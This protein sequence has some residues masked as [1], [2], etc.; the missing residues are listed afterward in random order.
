MFALVDC[1][2]F[3]AS[4]EQVFEPKLRGLP[5]VVLSNNDGCI[6][7]RSAEAK[8]LGIPMGAPLFKVQPTIRHHGVI[9]RSS[10]YALYG[11][12]S[13]RVMSVLERFAPAIEIYSIDEAF[14]E[15]PNLPPDQRLCWAQQLRQTVRQWLGIPIA[16][17]IAPTKTLAKVANHFAK[18]MPDLEGVFDLSAES[19]TE[20]WLAQLPVAD[21]W[22]IGRRLGV[23]CQDH[24]IDTALRLRDTAKE[25]LRRKMGIVGVRLQQELRGMACLAL[26]EVP[27]PKKETCVSRS[28]GSPVTDLRD[29]QEAIALYALRAGEKLR[30]QRQVTRVLTVFIRSSPFREPFYGNAATVQLPVATQDSFV[31]VRE[32]RR[33]VESLYRPHYD[34]QKAGILLQALQPEQLVQQHLWVM[35]DSPERQRLMATMDR[36]NRRF[37]QDL[38]KI[39]TRGQAKIINSLIISCYHEHIVGLH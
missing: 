25:R 13:Q 8:A 39:E 34:Y 4:C 18:R 3:Y 9:V 37:G 1:N 6:V 30:R 27:E 32:A 17:G 16:I 33:L 22:G 36:L 29:L 10:N 31:L 24:G 11:D 20:A 26:D 38:S 23:W 28:F 5:L 21:V 15:V 12:L 2:N 7:A 14:L 35:G 19:S